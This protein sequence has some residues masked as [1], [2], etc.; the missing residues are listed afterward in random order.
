[1]NIDENTLLKMLNPKYKDLFE[2]VAKRGFDELKETNPDL[3]EQIRK[4][5]VLSGHKTLKIGSET[6]TINNQLDE[7]ANIHEAEADDMFGSDGF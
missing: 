1:M 2:L 7:W 3:I 6:L 4:E 5:L